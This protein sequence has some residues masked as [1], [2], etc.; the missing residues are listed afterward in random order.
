MTIEKKIA[1]LESRIHHQRL[2]MI[3]MILVLAAALC[4]GLTQQPPK[5]MTLEGLT[6]MKDG[7]AR[8]AIG[9][10][11]KDGSVGIGLL[12]LQGKIRIAMATD[13]KGDGGMVVMDKNDVPKI[14]MGS[15]P[16]GS[17]IML[18]GASLTEVP[19][20]VPAQSAKE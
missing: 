15:G 5:Q 3:S 20:P 17:G 13:A 9:T 6:I 10:N 19:M 1:A 8:I 2:G 7:K 18:I 12:D 4:L 11:Q 16:D 14:L